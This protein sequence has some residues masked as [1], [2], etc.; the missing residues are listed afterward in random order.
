MHFIIAINNG[1][2]LMIDQCSLLRLKMK[3]FNYGRKMA[4][5]WLKLI[6]WRWLSDVLYTDCNEMLCLFMLNYYLF[7]WN[8]AHKNISI[9]WAALVTTVNPSSLYIEGCTWLL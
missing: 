5:E 2:P 3:T 4:V 8:I 6:L 7:A 1:F 9:W